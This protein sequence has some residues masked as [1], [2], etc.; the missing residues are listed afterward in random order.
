MCARIC[1]HILYSGT[2]NANLCTKF[3]K[4]EGIGEDG[5]T[6]LKCLALGKQLLRKG[7]RQL[8]EA[9]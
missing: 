6:V 1:I 4:G 8:P 9:L 2:G 7:L 3:G 5:M